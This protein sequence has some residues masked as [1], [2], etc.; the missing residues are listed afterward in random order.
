MHSTPGTA[1]RNP[2]D[3]P[4]WWQ[5]IGLRTRL[6]AVLILT[7]LV[8]M[9]I[10]YGLETRQIRHNIDTHA[11]HLLTQIADAQQRRLN[12]ELRRLNREIEL[13][14]SRTQMRISLQAYQRHGGEHDRKLIER[15]LGDALAVADNLQGIWLRGTDNRLVASQTRPEAAQLNPPA[16]QPTTERSLAITTTLHCLSQPKPELW[17]TQALTLNEVSIGRVQ[18]LVRLDDIHA[19]IQDFTQKQLGMQSLLIVQDCSNQL[20]TYSADAGCAEAGCVEAGFNRLQTTTSEP[21]TNL[22]HCVLRNT[23]GHP[24]GRCNDLL[25]T[26]RTIDLDKT[27]LLVYFT[28]E[29]LDE[30]AHGRLQSLLVV[31]IT[32]IL[33]TLAVAFWLTRII[34]KPLTTLKRAAQQVRQGNLQVQIKER[35]WGEFAILTQSFNESIAMLNEYTASLMHEIRTRQHYEQKL[36]QLANT[37]TLTGLNNRRHFLELLEHWRHQPADANC[38]GALFYLDLDRFKPINDHYG[39]DAGDTTLKIVAERLRRLVREQDYVARLGGDEFA[40]FLTELV[41]GYE[42]QPVA[43]RIREALAE[44]LVIQNY[45]VTIGCS[46]GFV[47][48]TPAS[49][50]EQLITEADAAMYLD[51]KGS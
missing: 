16:V 1:A 40:I 17:L 6:F 13:I 45:H 42:P 2:T 51:K 14:A 3:K 49:T 46:V 44:P 7:L 21:L 41:P 35:S 12:L 48:A 4:A 39:H 43:D 25:Y 38:Q 30:M 36:T 9:G 28:E 19:L 8:P 24:P 5:R 26:H 31:S 34:T 32:S 29:Q 15:I 23:A 27:T 11:Q 33:L 10:L 20:F 22:I 37:D 18:I 47:L 50:V